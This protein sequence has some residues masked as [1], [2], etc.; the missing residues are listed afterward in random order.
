M[1][2]IEIESANPEIGTYRPSISESN[3]FPTAEIAN[4]ARNNILYMWH[5]PKGD[6]V[7]IVWEGEI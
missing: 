2:H 5:L 4:Q 7:N 6:K 1:Y 3:G